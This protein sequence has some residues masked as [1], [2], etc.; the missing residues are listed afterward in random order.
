ME[1]IFSE[2]QTLLRGKEI[3]TSNKYFQFVL[4]KFHFYFLNQ[5]NGKEILQLAN[6]SKII[7]V[8]EY[9][10]ENDKY[11]FICFDY[12]LIIIFFKQESDI[13]ISFFDDF[14]SKQKD[15]EKYFFNF[16]LMIMHQDILITYFIYIYL[17]IILF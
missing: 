5:K 6:N 4:S 14:F 16:V 11:I 1:N 17:L 10:Q 13:H 12:N 3:K 8:D 2:F 7:I 9:D 15:S